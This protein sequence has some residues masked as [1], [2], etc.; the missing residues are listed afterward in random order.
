M[1]MI[2]SD[3]I[4]LRITPQTAAG[5]TGEFGAHSIEL[6]RAAKSAVVRARSN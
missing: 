3:L 6:A 4:A 5:V 2:E 1:S